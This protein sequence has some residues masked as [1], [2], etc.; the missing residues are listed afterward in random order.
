[1]FEFIIAIL[2]AVFPACETDEA[3]G[4]ACAWNGTE[5]GDG[6]GASFIHVGPENFKIDL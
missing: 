2:F 3:V 1:M 6:K 5:Q 4:P